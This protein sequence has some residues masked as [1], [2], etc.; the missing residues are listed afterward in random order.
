MNLMP[1]SVLHATDC[2]I[3]VDLVLAFLSYLTCHVSSLND[4]SSVK[5]A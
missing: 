1:T 4:P 3:L 2:S 5:Q